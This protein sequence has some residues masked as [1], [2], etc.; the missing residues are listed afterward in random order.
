MNF[1]L[2]DIQSSSFW[3]HC[4]LFRAAFSLIFNCLHFGFISLGQEHWLCCEFL[5]KLCNKIQLRCSDFF[6]K[7]FHN[8]WQQKKDLGEKISR[9]M[10]TY[11][12]YDSSN[13]GIFMHSHN[14]CASIYRIYCTQ[15]Q[16]SQLIVICY[17]CDWHRCF[18]SGIWASAANQRA[19]DSNKNKCKIMTKAEPKPNANARLNNDSVDSIN[20][21]EWDKCY[22]ILAT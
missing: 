22:G 2:N 9:Y 19:S 11:W 3:L 17:R 10:Y 15:A 13:D 7:K 4:W 18:S 12:V 6:L 21:N 16:S 14:L 5:S 1:I 20:S 8:T